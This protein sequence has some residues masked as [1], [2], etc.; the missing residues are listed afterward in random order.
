M[1]AATIAAHARRMR[2]AQSASEHLLWSQ[3]AGCKL[4]VAFRRQYVVGKF[5]ADFAAPSR[6]VIVE[7]DGGYHAARIRADAARDAK[8]HRLGWRVLRIPAAVVLRDLP[9]AVAIICQVL[10]QSE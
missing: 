4:G 2:N 3:L 8:L 5:V 1:H 9:R 10:K 6:R 7:V